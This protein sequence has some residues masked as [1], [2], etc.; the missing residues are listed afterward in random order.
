M[1]LPPIGEELARGHRLVLL[2]HGP[3]SLAVATAAEVGVVN[4]LTVTPQ[5]GLVGPDKSTIVRWLRTLLDEAP[6]VI[7]VVTLPGGASRF[8]STSQLER[9]AEDIARTA[10]RSNVYVGAGTL[11]HAPRRGRGTTAD[12]I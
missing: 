11:T 10:R 4:A 2:S 12:E 9:A 5:G 3:S 8:Y 1:E 6:G 7:A